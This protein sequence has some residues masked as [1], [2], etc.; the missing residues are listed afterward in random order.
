M[1]DQTRQ[2]VL[3]SSE[4]IAELLQ[5][6]GVS[7]TAQRMEIARVLLSRPQHL[8]ADQ[9]LARVN[10]DC[11]LVSKATVYN[12]MKVFAQKGLVREVTVDRNRVFYD[13]TTEPHHHFFNLDTGELT[14]IEPTAVEFLRLPE[15]PEGTYQ[16][17]V[18]VIVRL[19]RDRRREPR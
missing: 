10:R 11:P 18:E 14:D 9:I 7:P 1:D 6:R 19:R 15:L 8:S 16:E 13:S 3:Q 5:N 2:P 4:Q 17:G 12:T